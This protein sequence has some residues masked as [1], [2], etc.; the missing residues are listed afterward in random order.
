MYISPDLKKFANKNGF[1]VMGGYVYG[2]LGGYF[3]T[4]VEGMDLKIVS[5]ECD[6]TESE[7]ITEIFT[8]QFMKGYR[9]R[10]YKVTPYGIKVSFSEYIP[11][12]G[13]V[14]LFLQEFLN[15]LKVLN[16]KGDGFCTSCS[17][18]IV[19]PSNIIFSDGIVRRVHSEC[20]Q[21]AFSYVE[22]KKVPNNKEAK[23]FIG[24]LSTFLCAVLTYL[25]AF[26]ISGMFVE[27]L[28][29]K[30]AGMSFVS[31]FVSISVIN[32]AIMAIPPLVSRRS[33]SLFGSKFNKTAF[34]IVSLVYFLG[35]FIAG[36]IY[37]KLFNPDIGNYTRIIMI[38]TSICMVL[39]AVIDTFS[40][41]KNRKLKVETLQLVLH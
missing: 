34:V 38:V 18:D 37:L 32:T 6:T 24:A 1:M 15:H 17:R 28:S 16:V 21:K 12:M 11:V 30:F 3:V 29:E 35:I 8:P 9:I 19:S 23:V 4:F 39:P 31:T 2:L 36:N 14:K 40:A 26:F 41:Y 5:I 25:C 33:Y 22:D 13:K 20:I 27:S 10:N 7:K